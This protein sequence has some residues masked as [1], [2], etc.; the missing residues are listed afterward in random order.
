MITAHLYYQYPLQ[1]VFNYQAFRY[2]H[3]RHSFSFPGANTSVSLRDLLD[4]HTFP[5]VPKV[6]TDNSK[7]YS[8]G[9]RYLLGLNLAKSL[10]HLFDGP[11]RPLNWK[12]E[13]I[14]FPATETSTSMTVHSRHSPYI[15][16]SLDIG[17]KEN[18][19]Q[20]RQEEDEKF[21]YPMWLALAQILLELHL[22]RSLAYEGAE[23]LD[24]PKL[25][26]LLLRI[27]DNELRDSDFRPYKEAIEACLIFGCM[28][29]SI[30][31][32][33]RPEEAHMLIR[34]LI[35]AK[36]EKNYEKWSSTLGEYTDLDLTPNQQSQAPEDIA[37]SNSFDI[38]KESLE[39]EAE[40]NLEGDEEM[41]GKDQVMDKEI[42]VT[43]I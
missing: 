35:I 27:S 14:G 17:D 31:R 1:V 12:T 5:K 13:D 32:R 37:A 26:K 24:K 29:L 19:I 43:P 21:C 38:V 36:L 41:E 33:E 23:G 39:V 30:P 15:Q 11:W 42:W 40:D 9:D 28:L 34:N 8:F 4:K 6:D 22:G 16:F 3:E 7:Y 20:K 25:R 10:F 2:E 18:R